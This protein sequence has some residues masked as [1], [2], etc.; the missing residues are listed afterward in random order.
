MNTSQLLIKERFEF[1]PTRRVYIPKAN[2]KMRPLGVASPRDK[3]VQEAYRAI[4][5]QTLESIFSPRS[6]GFR[7]NRGC[8]SALA[9]IRY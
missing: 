2:G 5:E 9:E 4:L 1:R 8:H 6:H 7:P 3:I